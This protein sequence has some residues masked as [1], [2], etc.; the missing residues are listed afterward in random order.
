MV[1]TRE[2]SHIL[3]DHHRR[4]GASLPVCDPSA[5]EDGR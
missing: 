5:K 3:L 1:L 4:H 2:A